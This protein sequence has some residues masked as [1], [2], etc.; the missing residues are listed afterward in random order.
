MIS[1]D[2]DEA[3]VAVL[4]QN[5]TRLTELFA[6]INQSLRTISSKT[7]TASR[8][9]KPVLADFNTLTQK[10]QSVQD[11]LSLL[12]EVSIYSSRAAPLQK[13]LSSPIREVG[14]SKYLSSL[15]EASK[16]VKEMKSNIKDFDGVVVGFANTVDKAEL[17]VV[18]H[19]GTVLTSV[20]LDSVTPAVKSEV[21]AIMSYFAK[22]NQVESAHN[23]M[24]RS[25]G[26]MLETRLAKLEKASVLEKRAPNAPHEKG[27][28]PFTKYCESFGTISQQLAHLCEQLSIQELQIFDRV[29]LTYLDQHFLAVLGGFANFL[30][31]NS[32]SLITYDVVILEILDALLALFGVIS[33]LG[34]DISM[35]PTADREY[36]R[37]VDQ[38]LHLLVEWVRLVENRVNLAEKCT[39]HTIPEMVVEVLSKLR[40]IAE[41]GAVTQLIA[42]CKPGSW[43]EVEPPLRFISVYTSVI[44]GSAPTEGDQ[45]A[46]LV[47]SYLSDIIDEL[48]VSIEMRLRAQGELRKSIQGFMLVKN[49]VMVE[50]I[51]NRLEPLYQKLGSNG[52]E[53]L[54]RLKNRFLKLFLDDWNYASYIIIRDM[55]QITTTNAMHGGLNST[56]EKDQIK[57]LF[58]NFNESFEEALRQYEK[59][60][61]QEKVLRQYLSNEI[62]K[63]ILNAYNKL[64]DKF[65]NSDFTKNRA[66]Y[67]KYDKATFERVLNERL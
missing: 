67:V 45:V 7:L 23:T 60:N 31:A 55:T 10:K 5:L 37:F 66:K 9:I 25:F 28:M 8:S 47:S 4:T 36:T 6:D 15:G 29:F 63:L 30:R 54:L 2:V 51:I 18:G 53:R 39:D 43:L 14:V 11:A 21:A 40:R 1:V 64:Y 50:T 13:T 35:A 22:T 19:F 20:D 26:R 46:F 27:Q 42:G 16:L 17:A 61:I 24:E 44:A 57:E 65:G 32:S 48:M 58:K 3:D 12:L 34:I 56:K 59:F 41:S 33:P 52:L 38:T 62:K 49:L